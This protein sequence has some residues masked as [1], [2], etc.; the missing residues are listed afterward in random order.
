[1]DTKEQ[2]VLFQS[3]KNTIFAIAIN[4][5]GSRIAFV[6]KNGSLRLLDARSNSVARVISAH[7]VRILDVKFSPDDR[8]IA[9]SSMDKTVKIWDAVSLTNRPI[10]INK[11]N[12]WV[13]SVA[14][15][16]DGKY[17]VSSSEDGNIYYWP[18]HASYLAEQMCGK[19]NRNLTQREWEMYVSYDIPY[20]K[21]CPNK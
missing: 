6:D 7:T 1:M 21:T 10:I 13:L 19:V 3:D 11:H 12:T 14:F 4:S 16:P 18:T 9:T 15:S 2:T 8:Q 5:T 20:Q 17:L